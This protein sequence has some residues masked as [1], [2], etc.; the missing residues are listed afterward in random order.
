MP[1]QSSF[2]SVRNGRCGT[3]TA[4]NHI[5]GEE[6]V[7]LRGVLEDLGLLGCDAVS[8]GEKFATFRVSQHL[9]LQSEA[10]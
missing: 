1:L 6:R 9:H 8:F 3:H 7:H 4:R 10:V 2:I 5:P